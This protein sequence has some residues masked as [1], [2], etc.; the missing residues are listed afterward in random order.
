[1]KRLVEYAKKFPTWISF[2][3]LQTFYRKYGIVGII[4][5]LLVIPLRAVKDRNVVFYVDLNTI[6]KTN[7]IEHNIIE[8]RRREGDLSEMDMNRLICLRGDQV[9]K[10][11]IKKR[12][13]EGV[14]L[15]L[16]KQNGTIASFCWT[17]IGMTPQ[18]FPLPLGMDDVHYFD[19]ETFP[20]FR[21]KGLAPLLI[22]KS[23][24]RFKDQGLSRAYIDVK[25]WNK[26]SLSFVGRTLFKEFRTMRILKIFGKNIVIW[27]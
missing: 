13:S 15:W 22:N 20:E 27:S 23:L 25:I 19:V 12:F 7:N 26:A 9:I 8:E 14:V 3:R 16:L 4:K 11:T 6:E 1:M 24:E 2:E 18:K 21:G 10:K 5:R 17:S